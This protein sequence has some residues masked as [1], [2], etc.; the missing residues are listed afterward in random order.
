[1]FK[2]KIPTGIEIIYNTELDNNLLTTIPGTKYHL[3]GTKR[4]NK[5]WDLSIINRIGCY[6]RKIKENVKEKEFKCLI[7]MILAHPE[8]Q[9]FKGLLSINKIK[10]NYKLL[11]M[12]FETRPRSTSKAQ[13]KDESTNSKR[14]RKHISRPSKKVQRNGKRSSKTKMDQ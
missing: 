1:M 10:E 8:Q 5:N 11:L 2:Q 7:S 14:K 12:Q 4:E 3:L 9:D 13:K 6:K